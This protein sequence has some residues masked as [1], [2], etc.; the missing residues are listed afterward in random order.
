MSSICRVCH[1]CGEQLCAAKLL[2]VT[3]VVITAV[4]VLINQTKVV[5][6]NY[7]FF[8]RVYEAGVLTDCVLLPPSFSK[9]LCYMLIDSNAKIS[10]RT[11]VDGFM[12]SS[13]P[14][15]KLIFSG[16]VHCP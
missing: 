4:S 11:A 14:T 8:G 5:K 7:I 2:S 13:L 3:V 6:Y 16:V 9:D 12:H 15:R 1:V 10:R